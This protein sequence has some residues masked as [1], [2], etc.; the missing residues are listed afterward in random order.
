MKIKL[1]AISALVLLQLTAVEKASAEAYWFTNPNEKYGLIDKNARVILK[2]AFDHVEPFVSGFAIV[3]IGGAYAS[4]SSEKYKGG[5]FGM[6]SAQGKIVIPVKYDALEDLSEGLAAFCLKGRCGFLSPSGQIVVQPKFESARAFSAGLAPVKGKTGWGYINKRGQF[7]IQPVFADA[8]SFSEG[9][10]VVIEDKKYYYINT[11]GE[12]ILQDNYDYASFFYGGFAI[13]GRNGEQFVISSEGTPTGLK[14]PAEFSISNDLGSGI[15]LARKNG[16]LGGLY[17]AVG[18]PLSPENILRNADPFRGDLS[19]VELG[20]ASGTKI[21]RDMMTRDGKLMVNRSC[22]RLEAITDD[23]YSATCKIPGSR[24]YEG[25][26][27]DKSGAWKFSTRSYELGLPQGEYANLVPVLVRGRKLV[28]KTDGTVLAGHLGLTMDFPAIGA[29]SF[30]QTRDYSEAIFYNFQG[31]EMYRVPAFQAFRLENGYSRFHR[32]GKWGYLDSRGAVAI[33]PQFA[34]VAD[35]SEGYAVVRT[36]K[37]E[38]LVII[39]ARGEEILRTDCAYIS[40]VQ[41]G[42]FG[43]TRSGKTTL[44]NLK[45]EK[46]VDEE[47]ASLDEMSDG[48]RRAYKDK[49]MAGFVNDRGM[50]VI[51]ANFHGVRPFSEGL[52]AA[53]QGKLCGYIGKN[54][55]WVVQPAYAACYEFTSGYARVYNNKHWGIINRKGSVIVPFNFYD[56]SDVYNNQVWLRAA[57]SPTEE[58]REGY[59]RTKEHAQWGLANLKGEWILKPMFWNVRDVSANQAVVEI[60]ANTGRPVSG[61]MDREGR[62]VFVY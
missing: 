9:K 38:P 4:Q 56:A 49:V 30:V 8:Y 40:K 48:L 46:V 37:G 62:L 47:F 39:N 53:W 7:V 55:Q 17:N 51:P 33:T 59:E 44:M 6:V 42:K 16:I 23:E 24:L 22:F 36:E 43:C 20:D 54:G 35:F 50:W 15:F 25:G 21:T 10:A 3:N 31:K 11:R 27:L 18:N 60:D 5:K 41:N 26:I 29:T 1:F 12:K 58:Q 45:G 2:P 32:G 61:Y 57:D 14:S 34:D 28:V 13:V 19:V 52:A